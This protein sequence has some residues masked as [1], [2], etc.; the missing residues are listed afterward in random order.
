MNGPLIAKYED[1]SKAAKDR[2]VKL[3][4][5]R[6]RPTELKWE[7]VWEPGKV[8]ASKTFEI[9]FATPSS[10][11]DF[12]MHKTVYEVYVFLGK[13]L[14][15]YLEGNRVKEVEVSEGDLVMIPPGTYHYVEIREGGAYAISICSS[16]NCD[17]G[18]DKVVLNAP[19]EG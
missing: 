18:R 14:V 4:V 16:E 1:L 3:V 5:A 12:H 17:L 19:F 15:K 7:S 2:G 6:P 13:G 8:L 10:S 11:Q 9:G